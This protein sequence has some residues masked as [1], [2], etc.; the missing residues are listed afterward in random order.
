MIASAFVNS[1]GSVSHLRKSVAG[2]V[3]KTLR[4]SSMTQDPPH[5]LRVT[6]VGTPK[7]KVIGKYEKKRV[8]LF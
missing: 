2:H 5:S 6:A 7:E 1:N 8:D 4:I 3:R